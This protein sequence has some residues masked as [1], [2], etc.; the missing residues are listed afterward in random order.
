[1]KTE[2]KME[3]W[4]LKME[5]TK[6]AQEQH[7]RKNIYLKNLKKIEEKIERISKNERNNLKN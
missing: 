6:L 5:L 7:E 4:R 3:K 1:M 2:R